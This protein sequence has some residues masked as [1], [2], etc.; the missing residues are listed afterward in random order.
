MT[1]VKMKLSP[2]VVGLLVC[3]CC[4]SRLRDAERSLACTGSVCGVSFPVIDGIPVLLN[5][6]NSLFRF[7][8]FSAGTDT[9]Y[10]KAS[11]GRIKR[12]LTRLIPD[13]SLNVKAAENYKRLADELRKG[14]QTPRILVLGGSVFNR[15]MEFLLGDAFELIETDVSFGTRTQAIVDGH[16]IPFEDNCLDGVVVHAV[17]EHVLDPVRCVS[18]IHRVLKPDGLVY[19]ETPFIQQVHAGP[20]D[21]TRFTH[22]GHRRLFR[23]F[24]EIDSGAACGSGMALA[25]SYRH[26]LTSFST[27]PKVRSLLTAFAHL[28]AFWLKWF[29]RHLIDKPGC[30]DAASGV[31][32]LGRKSTTA[33]ADRDLIKGYRGAIALLKPRA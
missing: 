11:R 5:E 31:Y 26:F 7:S 20:Y 32:F 28:T 10:R 23:H 29:D 33:L 12:S 6:S 3:P 8:D 22:L 19:A 2:E 1:G 24:E 27:H 16:N 15:G 21:F 14:A 9:F 17:L 30:L 25:W 13:C 18:E 4:G